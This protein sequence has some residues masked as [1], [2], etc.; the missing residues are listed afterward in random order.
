MTPRQRLGVR[1]LTASWFFWELA[2]S[3]RPVHLESAWVIW[4][5]VCSAFLAGLLVIG[6]WTRIV[7]TLLGLLLMVL[8]FATPG[9]IRL[10]G[11]G[12]AVCCLAQ[13]WVDPG[14]LVWKRLPVSVTTEGIYRTLASV[15]AC[16]CAYVWLADPMKIRFEQ[17]AM[18]TRQPWLDL[19]WIGVVGGALLWG[20][21]VVAP[22]RPRL[23]WLLPVAMALLT[24]IHA[25]FYIDSAWMGC[26]TVWIAA[27]WEG[28]EPSSS[29][30][31]S[32]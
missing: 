14:R 17:A 5:T 28:E 29:H 20:L 15:L 11:W 13:G 6:C 16:S 18:A 23:R 24:L 22:W 30:A 27:Y 32:T 31:G 21:L 2:A 19:G 26:I 7:G 3:F 1:W 4:G 10:E 8:A 9:L 25:L 12:I